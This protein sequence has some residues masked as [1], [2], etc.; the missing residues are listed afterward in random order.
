MPENRFYI[1]TDF[2]ENAP[3]ELIGDEL[4]HLHV[5]RRK[6]GDSIELANGKG[7]LA[8]G[9]L[10]DLS[11]R[12]ALIEVDDIS[13]IPQ[14]TQKII[15]AQ[16]LVRPSS[17][18]YI[19]E[20][21][22]ELGASEFWLYPATFS[23]KKTISLQQNLRLKNL[24][25]SALK[26]CGRLYLPRIYEKP[27]LQKWPPFSGQIF[28]GDIRPKTPLFSKRSLH[29]Q[30]DILFFVG[31]EK[32]LADPEITFLEKSLNATGVSLH[33]NTLRVDTASLAAVFL[34]YLLSKN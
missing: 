29:S 24:T 26:Q 6:K 22:T 17:L 33:E 7:S 30:K 34:S 9:V 2:K 31:P 13:H 3:V 16:A 1:D 19:I 27:P 28:F 20:K 8:K 14:Q 15:L 12:S 11:K 5:M 21:G 18:E 32:G 4:R 10:I 25:I 23:E